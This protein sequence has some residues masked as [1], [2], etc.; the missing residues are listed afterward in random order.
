ML[1]PGR[2]VRLDRCHLL[3][4][5]Q[6]HV[7]LPDDGLSAA[8][9]RLHVD[10]VAEVPA[11]GDLLEMHLPWETGLYV[12]GECLGNADED[13]KRV[14]LRDFEQPGGGAADTGGRRARVIRRAAGGD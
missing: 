3:S 13:A 6:R 1:V 4:F 12:P 11:D 10:G 8:E 7:R 5:D 2:M 14:D 9:S